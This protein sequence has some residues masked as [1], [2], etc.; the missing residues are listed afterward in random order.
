MSLKNTNII[1]K[2]KLIN[3]P[4]FSRDIVSFGMI[5]DINISDDTIN[6]VLSQSTSNEDVLNQIKKDIINKISSISD[7]HSVEVTYHKSDQLKKEASSIKRTRDIKNI[8]AVASGK[9]GVGKSTV[10]I[11][12]AA[13]LSKSYKVGLLDLDIYGPSIPTLIGEDR[14]PEVRGNNLLI[15][16]EKFGMKFMS[17][18]FLNSNLLKI[19][20]IL[21]FFSF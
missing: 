7:N 12:L 6:I 1:E 9:G 8:I 21:I 10:A 5:K 11:N 3:Y 2:L 18:G 15:P 4:G 16:I 17:F 13:E 20:I 14:V 19:I